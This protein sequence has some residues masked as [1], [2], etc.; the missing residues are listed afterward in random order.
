MSFDTFRETVQIELMAADIPPH[1]ITRAE[2][3]A[4]YVEGYTAA[5]TAR[6]FISYSNG[7]SNNE[8]IAPMHSR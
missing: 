3:R 5:E 6:A 1:A 8:P 2:L 7:D 4:A